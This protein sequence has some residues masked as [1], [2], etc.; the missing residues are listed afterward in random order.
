MNHSD[1]V[2]LKN[3]VTDFITEDGSKYRI[4]KMIFLNL[5]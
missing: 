1:S 5:L 4:F 3:L 2:S